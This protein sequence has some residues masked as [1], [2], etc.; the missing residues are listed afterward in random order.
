MH[1]SSTSIEINIFVATYRTTRLN[2]TLTRAPRSIYLDKD[3]NYPLNNLF[4][5]EASRLNQND[6]LLTRFSSNIFKIV[7]Y[8]LYFGQATYAQYDI[9]PPK[10]N[11]FK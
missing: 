1:D 3:P 11:G 10:F 5:I 7:L 4:N 9:I 2:A 6:H 8:S